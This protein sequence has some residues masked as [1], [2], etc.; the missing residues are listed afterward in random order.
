MKRDMTEPP[1]RVQLSDV[2]RNLPDHVARMPYIQKLRR[3]VR[4]GLLEAAYTPD[5]FDLPGQKRR[6]R[7]MVILHNAAFNTWHAQTVAHARNT[8]AP[9][10]KSRTSTAALLTGV[11]WE[12]EV[13]RTRNELRQRKA[14]GQ[15]LALTGTGTA[16]K[17]RDRNDSR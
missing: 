5:R 14:S 2:I 1:P 15:A 6:I 11:N 10:V 12:Q 16:A 8:S 9:R 13:E 4:T 3:A 17:H 7:E